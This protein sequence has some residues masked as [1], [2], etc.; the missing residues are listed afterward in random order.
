MTNIILSITIIITVAVI[1]V[2][3]LEGWILSLSPWWST[4]SPLSQSTLSSSSHQHYYRH[5]DAVRM[6]TLEDLQTSGNAPDFEA[7]EGVEDQGLWVFLFS[8]FF[9][10]SSCCRCPPPPP[11]P[12]PHHSLHHHQ[13]HY[14]ICSFAQLGE[15]I[16]SLLGVGGDQIARAGETIG[17]SSILTRLNKSHN[18][19]VGG[20][21]IISNNLAFHLDNLFWFISMILWEY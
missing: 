1:M 8:C 5:A 11:P 7:R 16:A 2:M 18:F 12:H 4:T 6:D 19:H 17:I 14:G 15:G 3:M 10:Y 20:S 21:D 9:F 13:D